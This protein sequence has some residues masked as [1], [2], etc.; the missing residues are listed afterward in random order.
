MP[1]Y[2]TATFF[3]LS[4]VLFWSTVA[5]SFKIALKDL[6]YI[7]VLTIATYTSTFIFFFT[8]IIKKNFY[9]TFSISTKKWFFSAISGFLNPFLYYIVLLKAYSIL[10][11][12]MAQPLNYT[13]PVVLTIMSAWLLKQKLS[14]LSIV[15]FIFSL[16]GVFFIS[17]SKNNTQSAINI[18]GI[19]LATCSSII[20]SLYWIINI[21]D[22]RDVISKMFL[23]FLFGSIY[24]SILILFVDLP[25]IN[26]KISFLAAIYI[27][28]FEM[29]ITF[30]L[31]LT[32]LKK[33]IRTDKISIYIFLSPII[34]LFFIST[35]LKE[36]ISTFA[37]IGFLFIISGIIISKWKEIFT[38]EREK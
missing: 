35:I 37:I 9:E 32:A 7:Q 28:F 30:L 18:F 5:T 16:V 3:A 36:N 20:W 10:P 2:K 29:G 4:A 23:N 27:G 38:F 19:L 14:F 24:L 21:K 8:L 22:K 31:W 34:S 1:F 12:Y 26:Y 6:H 11:A 13:W 33:A 17:L 25:T 15:A